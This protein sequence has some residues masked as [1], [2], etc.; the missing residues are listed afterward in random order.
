MIKHLCLLTVFF[1][2]SFRVAKAQ[3]QYYNESDSITKYRHLY[4]SAKTDGNLIGLYDAF[5][6]YY[7]R[8]NIDS[9]LFYGRLG[10]KVS[11]KANN[12]IVETIFL[13]DIEY[14]VREMGDLAE[15]L[16]IQ[17]QTLELSKQLKVP[18]LEGQSLNS[19]GNTYMDM[20]DPRTGLNYYRASLA[21]FQK[22]NF[23]YFKLN[24]P[25]NMGNAYERLNKP[26]SA[27]FYE[28]PLYHNKQF[29]ADLLPELMWRLGNVSVKLGKYQEA[30]DYYRKGLAYEASVKTV[31]DKAQLYYLMAKVFERANRFLQPGLSLCVAPCSAPASYCP[32]CT[33]NVQISTAL[34]ITSK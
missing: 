17:L 31:T 13:A 6:H 34:T 33:A 20:G 10:L 4:R 5:S 26:D 30:L 12:K 2:L 28:L 9:A 8:N 15:A 11:Q 27:L 7:R 22:L 16:S 23:P 29:P 21:V 18:F 3:S 32:V 24:E 25:S 1:L 14:C 19:I